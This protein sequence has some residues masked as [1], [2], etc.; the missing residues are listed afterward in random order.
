MDKVTKREDLAHYQLNSD[1]KHKKLQ[2]LSPLKN[3]GRAAEN[4]SRYL[5]PFANVYLEIYNISLQV[6]TQFGNCG[7]YKLHGRYDNG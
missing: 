6:P 7:T 3:L 4:S 5:E 2:N 1:V